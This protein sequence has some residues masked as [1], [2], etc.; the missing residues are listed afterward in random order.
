VELVETHRQLERSHILRLL[1]VAGL[2]LALAAIALTVEIRL[3]FFLALLLSLLA[4]WSLGRVV[5]SVRRESD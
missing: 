1:A 2:S 3:P 4:A 5:G